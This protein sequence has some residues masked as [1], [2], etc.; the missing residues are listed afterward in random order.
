MHKKNI[1][2]K[3][4]KSYLETQVALIMPKLMD[5]VIQEDEHGQFVFTHPIFPDLTVQ[6]ITI[7]FVQE[8]LERAIKKQL[9]KQSNKHIDY[10]LRLLIA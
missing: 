10:V 2:M 4:E 5:R 9:K 6:G 3:Q 1:F 8:H 7:G